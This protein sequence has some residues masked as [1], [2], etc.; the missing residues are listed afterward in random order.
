MKK[1][2]FYALSGIV[3]LASSCNNTASNAQNRVSVSNQS[4]YSAPQDV[5]VQS[6]DIPGF[7][8]NNFANLLRSTTDPDALTQ[9]INSSGNNIN[10][11]DLDEDGSIDYLKV[12]QIDGNRLGVFDELPSGKVT[13]AT[14]TVNTA[15]RSY[16]I[17][18]TPDYCGPT[19]VYHSPVGLTFGDYLFLSWMLRPHAYYHPYWGYHRGYYRGYGAYRSHY[20]RPYSSTYV[21]ERRTITRTTTTRMAPTQ[22]SRTSTYRP[23]QTSAPRQTI[24]TPTRSQRSFTSGEGSR[25]RS[26]GSSSNGFRSTPSSSRSFGSSSSRSFGSSSSSRSFGSS[27]SRSFGSSSRSSGRRR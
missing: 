15:N 14:L 3:L 12:D 21:R 23:T 19:Y 10:N 1:L 18:G 16:V 26:S 27:S 24:S 11:L 13:I 5:N 4:G 20:S 8:V 9:A 7:D 2:I 6:N 22:T 25:F 17:N